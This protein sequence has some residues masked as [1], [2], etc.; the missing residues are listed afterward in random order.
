M[1]LPLTLALVGAV[2]AAFGQASG[3]YQPAAGQAVSWNV[4]LNHNM[5]WGGHPYIPVGVEIGPSA[6]AVAAA[7]K[8]GF[9]DVIVDMPP[10]GAGWKDTIVRLESGGMRYILSIDGL[11]PSAKGFA[12]EPEAY[13]IDHITSDRHVEF[14]LPGATSALAVLVTQRDSTVQNSERIPVSDGKFSYNVATKTDLDEVLLVYPEESEA[15]H[16]DFWDEFDNRRDEL[17]AELNSCKAGPGLRAILNPLGRMF[18][19]S[20]GAGLFVPESPYYRSELAAFLEAKYRSVNTAIRAWGIG[21]NDF[22]SFDQLARLA[23][24]WS[25][26]RGVAKIWDTSSNVL[27]DC[28]EHNTNYWLDVRSVVAAA[29]AKRFER[30][31][32]AVQTV[33]DVPVIEDWTGWTEPFEATSS[34]LSGIG[35]SD[36]ARTPQAAIEAASRPTSSILRWKSPGWLVCTHLSLNQNP[37]GGS[38]FSALLDQMESMGVRG[39]YLR[40]T[41]PAVLTAAS[42][43]AGRRESDT[44]SASVSPDPLFFPENAMNPAIPERLPGGKWWLP[45]PTDGNRLDFGSGYSGY[46]TSEGGVFSTVIWTDGPAKL[47]KLRASDPKAVT[48]SRIDGTPVAAKLQKN[49]LILTIDQVPLILKTSGEVPVPD[50]CFNDT[51]NHYA[52]LVSL[53]DQQHK[54]ISEFTLFIRDVVTRYDKDPGGALIALRR[55][56]WELNQIVAPFSWIEAEACRDTNF[57][58][59]VSRSACSGGAALLL[60]TPIT[61]DPKGF[62]ADYPLNSKATSDQEVWIS[63][64]IPKEAEKYVSVDVSGQHLSILDGPI[65]SYG[66]GY[67]WYRMGVTRL[68][69]NNADLILRVNAPEGAYLA[70][71]VVLLY[72]GTFKPNGVT[73]PDA[74]PFV[75][76]KEGKGRK[77]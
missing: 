45:A 6:D 28:D 32:G 75:Q 22:D 40:D 70:V 53:A 36:E 54:E 55:K 2:C 41:N 15:N 18:D 68:L 67:G 62:Y 61:T 47:T 29:A 16:P 4:D 37:D 57:S 74:V 31:I 25:G 38:G 24:L 9:Q 69:G 72:P 73:M 23:P 35:F 33:A 39:W 8:S 49:G 46:V 19:D 12:I 50:E 44:V 17:L 59:I 1:R 34:V 30:L 60:Q 71:D 3:I 42:N 43:D 51:A 26:T 21:T 10:D 64:R 13:R 48:I 56:F 11:F 77:R 63:G 58:Q 27:Y 65:G 7:K 5:V 76:V 14:P 52:Q 66:D 20:S